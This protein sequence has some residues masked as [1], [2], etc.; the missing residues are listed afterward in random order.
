M[1]RL[2]IFLV[3]VPLMIGIFLLTRGITAGQTSLVWALV[4]TVFLIALFL[5]LR[6]QKPKLFVTYE[7]RGFLG[8]SAYGSRT[9]VPALRG[10][11]PNH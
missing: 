5:L 9:R 1:K 7:K 11:C 3:V 8:G 10:L 6:R 4:G 2:V